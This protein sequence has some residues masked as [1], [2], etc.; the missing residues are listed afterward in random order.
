MVPRS[1][2][3][4]ETEFELV[5]SDSP[6]TVDGFAIGEP[7]GE[8]RCEAC[9]AAHLNVDEIPHA[10]DCPQRWVRSRWWVRQMRRD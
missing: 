2:S 10:S 3:H 4:P 8:V 7:T 1:F 5:T 6:P 9:G